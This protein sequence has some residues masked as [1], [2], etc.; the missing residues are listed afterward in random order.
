MVAPE[1]FMVNV[2]QIKKSAAET[3]EDFGFFYIHI[4]LTLFIWIFVISWEQWTSTSTVHHQHVR[5]QFISMQE[6]VLLNSAVFLF[7]TLDLMMNDPHVKDNIVCQVGWVK[8][9]TYLVKY[10]PGCYCKGDFDE[11]KLKMVN[12]E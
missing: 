7:V 12:L 4:F 6:E 10:Y 3:T 1:E 5:F 2:F 8:V 11:I 9:P